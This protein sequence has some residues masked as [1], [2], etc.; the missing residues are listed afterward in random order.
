[1]EIINCWLLKLTITWI[2]WTVECNAVDKSKRS[3]QTDAL[4]NVE[5]IGRDVSSITHMEL[6][7][8]KR[9]RRDSDFERGYD[10]FL[11][12]YHKDNGIERHGR[13]QV[14]ESEENESV[15]SSADESDED[16]DNDDD[17]GESE[18]SEES[19]KKYKSK[20]QKNGKT[21]T[22]K[23]EQNAGKK[24]SKHCKTEKKGNM[25]CNICYDPKNDAKAES[26]SYNSDP[27]EK[28]YAY[29]EDTSYSNRDKDPESL[30]GATNDDENDDREGSPRKKR[31]PPPVK[32][33]P[34]NHRHQQPQYQQQ[35]PRFYGTPQPTHSNGYQ[36]QNGYQNYGPQTF[37]P[38]AYQPISMR[39]I[40]GGRPIRIRIKN[41]PPPPSLPPP[42][43]ALIRYRTVEPPFGNQ[44]IRL[45]TYPSGPGSGYLPPPPSS[46]QQQQYYNN[47]NN[48]RPVSAAQELRPPRDINRDINGA[49]SESLLSN[50]TKEHLFE[51]L[52]NHM[53]S[54]AAANPKYAAF[55]SKDWS[56][57]RKTVE[58]NQVCFECYVDGE[59]RKECMF[60]NVN[61][62][63]NF[64]KSYSTSKKFN[65]NH[66]YAY[67]LP[68]PSVSTH[69][70][71]SQKKSKSHST[72]RNKNPDYSVEQ[73]GGDDGGGG[74]DDDRFS[75]DLKSKTHEK[76]PNDSDG[77]D[78][79]HNSK[80][81]RPQIRPIPTSV[82]DIIY[83]T[84]KAGQEPLALFFKTDST[85]F[86]TINNLNN[87]TNIDSNA[88]RN[89]TV[90]T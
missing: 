60:A 78:L 28:N 68:I 21:K 41:G 82:A 46:P 33:Y 9:I 15:D 56:S 34:T 17:D 30:E 90:S 89:F 51:Y 86:D 83:G 23:S 39:P 13:Y 32:K 22:K 42:N 66:P 72:Q 2:I 27:K 87:H 20:P 67:D 11:R 6:E 48:H 71:H 58:M 24:K 61:R 19:R 40:S 5:F 65:T 1:M 85:S 54:G 45:I 62:P 70:K 53:V 81:E 50:V 7:D 37:L 14:A 44:H 73:F 3:I 26:C 49:H 64:Y 47:N 69:T 57:C 59:R 79:N 80:H 31:P 63:D 16:N 88:N 76:R 4:D 10:E 77:W 43:V 36:N 8:D 84:V 29:S 75:D 35:G 18:S 25:V 52:P 12:N 74:N 38:Q 55:I